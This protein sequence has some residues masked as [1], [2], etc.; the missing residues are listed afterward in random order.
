ME[1]FA[2]KP[3][4]FENKG[5]KLF[6]FLHFPKSERRMVS[7]QQP[8]GVVFCHPFAEEKVISHRVVFNFVQTL[9]QRGYHVLRFDYRGCGDSEGDFEQAT[10]TT[11]IADIRSAI[12][13]L[14]EHI[15]AH[16][17]NLFG[18]RLGGTLAAL[19]ASVDPRVESLILWEPIVHVK[20]YFDKFLRMQVTA[21]H[22]REGRIVGT[23]KKL[24]KE[25]Q[26]GRCVDI[27]GY[28]LSPKCF[29]EFNKVDMLAQ[30]GCFRAST[31]IVAISKYKRERKDLQ[32]LLEACQDNNTPVQMLHVQERPF[33]ID[34]NDPFQEFSSWHD[35]DFLFQQTTDWLE[36]TNRNRTKGY[37]L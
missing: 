29:E 28:L 30:V 16:H 31:L 1:K 25:L 27:L 7:F 20:A 4:F 18:L 12:D 15:S 32:T 26:E 2:D 11:R 37:R 35:H 17:I 6:G 8:R 34:R 23:R 36:T 13:V 10:L 5:T 24:L 21:E 22:M 19:V 33:W 14:Q 9:C 3:F